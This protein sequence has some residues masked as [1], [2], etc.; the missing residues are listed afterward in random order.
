MRW[1]P[2]KKVSFVC[3]WC[4]YFYYLHTQAVGIGTH[5]TI[6]TQTHSHN[7]KQQ[8]CPVFL[9]AQVKFS[10]YFASTAVIK[11]RLPLPF[12][13]VFAIVVLVGAAAAP[14][15]VVRRLLWHASKDSCQG[16]ETESELES[17]S[18]PGRHFCLFVYWKFKQVCLAR[19]PIFQMLHQLKEFF[20]EGRTRASRKINTLLVVPSAIATFDILASYFNC[21]LWQIK[22]TSVAVATVA[23]GAVVVAT[24]VVAVGIAAAVT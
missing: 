16:L 19:F 4:T 22:F 20:L 7:R 3:I 1:L 24:A 15:L 14:I 17:E 5:T 21:K 8:L 6:H 18:Q 2:C 10:I 11:L 12:A 23:A 9:V 13:N